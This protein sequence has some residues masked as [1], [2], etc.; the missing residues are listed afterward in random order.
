MTGLC[1]SMNQSSP[2]EV[3][4]VEALKYGLVLNEIDRRAMFEKLV[5]TPI[6]RFATLAGYDVGNVLSDSTQT[7]I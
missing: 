7:T 1:A 4:R 3:I 2:E 5:I 6:T